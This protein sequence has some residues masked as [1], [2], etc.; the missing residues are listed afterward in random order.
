M[1]VRHGI[2][3]HPHGSRSNVPSRCNREGGV[4]QSLVLPLPGFSKPKPPTGKQVEIEPVLDWTAGGISIVE[5]F[6]LS[7]MLTDTGFPVISFLIRR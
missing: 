5:E 1:A 6:Q 4:S 3:A 7:L 2:P